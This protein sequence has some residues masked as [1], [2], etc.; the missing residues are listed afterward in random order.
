MTLRDISLADSGPWYRCLECG[1]EGTPSKMLRT[2]DD[3]GVPSAP[4]CKDCAAPWRCE[5][6]R[7]PAGSGEPWL[8]MHGVFA[9]E[10]FLDWKNDRRGT[11]H[12]PRCSLRTGPP[13]PEDVKQ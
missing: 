1:N 4:H 13:I 7:W 11:V 10:I 9:R 6:Q 2:K 3:F 5:C 8:V 12:H